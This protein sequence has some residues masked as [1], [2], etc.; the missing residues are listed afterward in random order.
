MSPK[1]MRHVLGV[2]QLADK[3]AIR[4]HLNRRKVMHASYCTI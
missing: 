2:M 1:R 4:Y 3:L